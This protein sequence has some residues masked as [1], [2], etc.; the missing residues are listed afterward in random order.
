MK[1]V[2]FILLMTF[3]FNSESEAEKIIKKREEDSADSYSKCY[4]E[5]GCIE[6]DS[7]WYD[8]NLRPVNLK[9][10][11]RHIIKTDF[12]LIKRNKSESG[13][14]LYNGMMAKYNSIKAAGFN[15]H[16]DILILIH[17]FT[18]NGYTGWIK[19]LST[20]LLKR[21]SYV[22]IISVDWQ[23]GA[24]P[25]YDQAISNARV[26]ALEIMALL[27]ELK[28]R[29][30]TKLNTVH[31]VGHGVG[32]HI[33]GYVGATYNN[34]KKITGL[35]PNGPRFEG[36]PDI[37]KLNP[38]CAKYVEVIHTDA[39]DSRSEGT[40]EAMGHSDFYI[41]DANLQPGC[42]ENTTFDG[43][44]S[45]DRSNLNEGKYY[46]DVVTKG[47]SKAIS[48]VKCVFLGIKCDSYEDFT[49][50][51][52][53]SCNK[54]DS[55]CRTFGLK[56]YKSSIQKS[57]FFLNTADHAPYCMF[58]YKISVFVKN[59]NKKFNGYFDFILVDDKADVA[60]ASLSDPVSNYRDIISGG[61]NTYIY[62][63]RPPKIGK[64]KEARVRWNEAK[65]I[66]CFIY[67]KQ[68]INVEKISIKFLGTGRD[69][70]G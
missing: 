17:D 35:D 7:R 49:K 12:L 51:K 63:A 57:T 55:T 46:P 52:C 42:P 14:L 60:E 4:D 27:K 65:K 41:N 69:D 47:P 1:L 29:F 68:V 54:T 34:I 32:A 10:L 11:D 45:V 48:D 56:Q 70:Q 50:G 64:I 36:M 53:I 20:V 5:L 58:E 23:R 62:Y 21:K 44:I 40:K 26:V 24:E 28:E 8:P 6:T 13:D 19:H 9:P 25:P 18:S 37:V 30:S 31:I 67:C 2:P 43:V 22:N 59:E 33:A 3:L 66:Y 39:F 61:S 38:T 16:A 15:I